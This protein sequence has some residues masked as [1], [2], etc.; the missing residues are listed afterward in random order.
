MQEIRQ[1]KHYIEF[2][3]EKQKND[4]FHAFME[5]VAPKLEEMEIKNKNRFEKYDKILAT[6]E[7]KMKENGKEIQQLTKNIKLIKE[8]QKQVE[9]K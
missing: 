8:K 4:G 2:Q 1:I 9:Q 7:D 5:M 3:N 6:L